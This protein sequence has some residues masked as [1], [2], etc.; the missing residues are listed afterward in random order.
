[1]IYKP[2]R[3]LYDEDAYATTFLGSV[4]ALNLIED[5][6]LGASDKIKADI[7]L[8]K[9]LFFPEEGGQNSDK[10]TMTI[11][12]YNFR[13]VHVSL[14][15][16][17][18]GDVIHHII[19]LDEDI[20]EVEWPDIHETLEKCIGENVSGELDWKD[21]F[22]KMQN[23]SGEHILSGIIHNEYGYDNVGFHLNDE[24]FTMDFN[25]TFTKEQVEF[26]ETRANEIVY[27]NVS[28]KAS[29]YTN[30]QLENMSYRSK[31]TFDNAVRIVTIGEYDACACCA[32]HVKTTAE[33]GVIKII[34]SESWKGGTRFTVICG[35]R[36]YKDYAKKQQTVHY[37]SNQFSTSDDMIIDIIDTMKKSLTVAEYQLSLL[38]TDTLF[39][40]LTGTAVL[41]MDKPVLI[42][43]NVSNQG[44]VR[45]AVDRAM[46]EYTRCIFGV[47]NGDDKEG[48]RY[49]FGSRDRD[50]KAILG[51]TLAKLG[52]KGGGN[53]DMLQGMLKAT[54]DV[55]KTQLSF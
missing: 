55:I 38:Q 37:I 41:D 52:A 31:K 16:S 28:I 19:E 15:Q 40:Q 36:A 5:K 8:D 44:A 45:T 4:V 54:K 51:D 50:V 7:I 21:R 9:T 29:Y 26:I 3:K 11:G 25:G 1:M 10:G 24:V 30:D 18:K 32:P 23:H 20:S 46:N 43:T 35:R 17:Q 34:K 12:D 13:V 48:Y 6:E 53:K 22:D 42:F 47:L 27:E 33:I 14:E 2:T 49:L 39:M